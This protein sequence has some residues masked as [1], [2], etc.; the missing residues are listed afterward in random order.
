[1]SAAAGGAAKSFLGKVAGAFETAGAETMASLTGA[2]EKGGK[3]WFKQQWG[4]GVRAAWT[5]LATEGGSHLAR[6][7]GGAAVGAGLGMGTHLATGIAGIPTS[8]LGLTN[9]DMSFGGLLNSG[10]RG[11]AIG[12]AIGAGAVKNV[13]GRGMFRPWANR[14]ISA[15]SQLAPNSAV[16]AAGGALSRGAIA[17]EAAL[18]VGLGAKASNG[19]N[20]WG[21]TKNAFNTLFKDQPEIGGRVG[22]GLAMGG[23]GFAAYS[24][25][26][27][28]MAIPSNYGYR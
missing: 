5:D 18:Q 24:S 19:V 28:S 1:M 25:N 12:G 7:A 22:A 6:A 10:I 4:G 17:P 14:A 9:N 23:M 15:G 2:M 8:M 27:L 13:N 11:A 3:E 26:A 21:R 16:K 20:Q